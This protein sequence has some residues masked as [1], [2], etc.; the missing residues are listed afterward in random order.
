MKKFLSLVTVL[1][2]TFSL[3]TASAKEDPKKTSSTKKDKSSCCVSDS[4]EAK[5]DKMDCCKNGKMKSTKGSC[6]M[7]KCSDKMK[8]EKTSTNTDSKN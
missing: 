6:D 5:S 2:L 8:A 3:A 1:A 4:K 7:S